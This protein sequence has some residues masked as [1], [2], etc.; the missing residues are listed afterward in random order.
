MGTNAA[1]WLRHCFISYN[2]GFWPKTY[3][4]TEVC[5]K[6]LGPWLAKGL[7]VHK[8]VILQLS[9]NKTWKKKPQN[10]S[11]F[12]LYSKYNGYIGAI[13]LKRILLSTLH[14][15]NTMTPGSYHHYCTEINQFLY[16]KLVNFKPLWITLFTSQ[17]LN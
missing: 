10:T 11:W 8:I 1:W 14:I 3:F 4:W 7:I 5:N 13:C 15:V 17:H 9:T 2:I 16:N 6:T 12:V